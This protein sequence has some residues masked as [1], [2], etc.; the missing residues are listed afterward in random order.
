MEGQEELHKKY[1]PDGSDLR[2]MQMRMLDMLKEVDRICKKYDIP[3]WL[4]GGTLLGSVRHGGFIPW[5]DELDIELM[6]DDFQRF[7][8]VALLDFPSN[9]AI[10]THSTDK[11]YYF[12]YAKVRDLQSFLV[13]DG[14]SDRDFK[15]KGIYIDVFPMANTSPFLLKI[16]EYWHWYC[17]L[18]PSFLSTSNVIL[19]KVCHLM[20]CLSNKIY[21][22]FRYIDR[23][24]KNQNINYGYGC[25]FTLNCPSSVIFPLTKIEFENY[26][27][28]APNNP[29]LYLKK[30]Y[31]DYLKLPDEQDRK[32]H[33]SHIAFNN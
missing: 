27:F 1:N 31:G 9:L 19:R 33:I 28:S 29:D 16:S 23:K 6:E 7:I 5:D 3:Y 10:Q 8:E 22:L 4:S 2:R 18:K 21:L 25:Q 15:Y 14:T 30:I 24:K 11:G 32:T 12:T 26:L 20:Y 17:V 13:E